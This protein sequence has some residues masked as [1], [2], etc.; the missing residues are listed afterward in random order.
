MDVEQ[1]KEAVRGQMPERRWQHTLGVIQ[2][3]KELAERFGADPAK[4]EL[5]A[6]LHDLAKYWP[7]G[8]QVRVLREA[9]VVPGLAPDDLLPF[10]EALFHA[11]VA[12]HVAESRY[13]I[14]DPEVLDAIRY[15][16]TGRERMT[17]LDKVVCLADYIEPGRD[18]PGV[19]EMRILAQT[20]L[21]A[22]LVAGFDSTILFLMQKGKK[23]FP[24]TVSARNGL[25]EEIGARLAAEGN[26]VQPNWPN[27]G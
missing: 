10:D 21:E 15:H 23:I 7:I 11:P 2:S 12:A 3:A 16:T 8:E 20:D 19:G 14:T 17:L 18:F 6:V 25:I 5:A 26:H 24:L 27:G 13:G 22:A 1:L 4:A 9:P